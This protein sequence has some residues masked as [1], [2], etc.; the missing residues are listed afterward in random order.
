M[1][2]QLKLFTDPDILNR[3]Q[4]AILTR[5][6][7][8]HQ[9]SLPPDAAALLTISHNC[10]TLQEYC[11]AWAAQFGAVDQLGAPLLQALRAIEFLAQRENATILNAALSQLPAGCEGNRGSSPLGQAL[12]LWLLARNTAGVTWPFCTLHS[13]HSAQ[14][15]NPRP[16]RR[17]R[18][19]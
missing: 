16:A 9:A 1:N 3:V 6:L 11:A 17:P 19:R 12:H 5:F 14:E 18:D 13:S 8:H 10:L 2:T 4:R 7:E 15:S